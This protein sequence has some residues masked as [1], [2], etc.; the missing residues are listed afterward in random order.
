MEPGG[1]AAAAAS[2]LSLAG[3]P[4][5][6]PA[7]FIELFMSACCS[8]FS[9]QLL[10]VVGHLAKTPVPVHELVCPSASISPAVWRRCMSTAFGRSFRRLDTQEMNG[11]R[12]K[13]VAGT[14][15]G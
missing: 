8:Q 5:V 2:M 7:L 1:G 11:K 14:S 3:V 6:G 13:D 4:L 9:Q 12:K 10:A 15:K